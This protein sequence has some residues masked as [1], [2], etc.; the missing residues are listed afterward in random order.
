MK[1][2]LA[3]TAVSKYPADNLKTA[4]D[5]VHQ[6][7]IEGS[8]LVAFPE[9]FMT[10]VEKGMS[11]A[12]I[13]EPSDGPFISGLAE[14]AEQYR[15]TIVCG[16]WQKVE[17]EKKRAANTVIVLGRDGSLQAEYRKIHLFD[18]LNVNESEQMVAG[19]IAPPLFSCGGIRF[20][21]AICYDLRFPELFRYL[22][23]QGRK[24]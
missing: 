4:S 5:A 15:V 18:A 7:S 6:A 8:D 12:E 16:V 21:L 22:A 23:R 20:G 17:G 14:L 13:A 19:S 3:Q 10:R 24:R 2:T 9:T 11:T 1:I